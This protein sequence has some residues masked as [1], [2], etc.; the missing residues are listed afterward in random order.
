M[1]KD[2]KDKLNPVDDS[3]TTHAGSVY[4]QQKPAPRKRYTP[5]SRP[6][7]E[8]ET[9]PKRT[10]NLGNAIMMSNI[11]TFSVVGIFMFALLALAVYITGRIWQQHEENVEPTRGSEQTSTRLPEPPEPLSDPIGVI[12]SPSS[13]PQPNVRAKLDTDA[14]RRAVMMQKR[15]EGLVAVGNFREAIERYQ[16]A[17]DIW[18]YLTEVWSQLG[19]VYLETKEFGRAQIAL[20]RAVESDPANPELLNDLG[21]ALLYQNR[22]DRAVEIF[23]TVNDLNPGYTPALFN[24]ALCALTKDDSENAKQYLDRFLRAKPTDARA[25]KERAYLHAMDGALNESLTLLRRALSSAP[26]WAPLY[27]DAAAAA[28]L[29]GRVDDA[30]RYLDKAE[31]LTS[32]HAVYQV[33]QQPAFREVRL[34]EPG[35]IFESNLA[36]RAREEVAVEESEASPLPLTEPMISIPEYL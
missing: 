5:R 10:G 35:K 7:A 13:S 11:R 21:V 30:V 26:D 34:T 25:L 17:L 9:A 15:A 4:Y 31:G 20:E 16:D 14:M 23:E 18:P 3:A 33:Y 1:S 24:L 22:I 29:L 36:D 2:F 6:T 12:P 32:P 8:P 19:R 27:F 28:A